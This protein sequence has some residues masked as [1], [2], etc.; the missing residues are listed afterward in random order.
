MIPEAEVLR[1]EVR[2]ELGGILRLAECAR[3]DKGAGQWADAL[4]VQIKL[5]AGN[6]QNLRSQKG[7]PVEAVALRDL[8]AQLEI[9]AE[10]RSNLKLLSSAAA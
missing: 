9:V 4:K 5:D 6:H 8:V 10:S 3:S 1:N 2:G 7:G